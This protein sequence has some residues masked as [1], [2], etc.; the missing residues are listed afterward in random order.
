MISLLFY[1]RQ[2]IEQGEVNCDFRGF[3]MGDSWIS[4]IGEDNKA[5][6][7]FCFL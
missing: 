3:A 5:L 4:P 1:A 6:L 2:A 7:T